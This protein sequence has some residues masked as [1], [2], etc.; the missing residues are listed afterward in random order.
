MDDPSIPGE[1]QTTI[2]PAVIIACF[3]AAGL[4]GALLL[5]IAQAPPVLAIDR[6]TGTR[7][8]DSL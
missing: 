6:C 4:R 3:A 5:Q 8:P 7:R 1:K 2:N